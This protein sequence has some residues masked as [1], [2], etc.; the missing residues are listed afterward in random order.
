M[1][2]SYYRRWQAG[3]AGTFL[4]GVFFLLPVA[5]TF[6]IIGWVITKVQAVLGPGTW[7]GQVISFGGSAIVGPHHELVAF[8]IGVLLAFGGIWLLGFV[9]QT[10]ARRTL[11]HALSGLL[12]RVPLIRTIYNPI[13]QVVELLRGHGPDDIKG[14]EVVLCRFG[15]AGAAS[16][17]ALLTSRTVYS[18]ESGPAHLV[19]LPTSPLPM[20]GGLTFVPVDAVTQV[21]DLDVDGLLRIYLSLGTLARQTMPPH[22]AAG[23]GF[24]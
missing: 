19:Y 1:D 17:L 13:E 9:V 7:L 16:V 18:L 6:A 22:F 14:M 11:D 20:S 23:S 3:V 15:A 21:E 24:D 10:R 5:L 4:T 12:S 2:S 8:W